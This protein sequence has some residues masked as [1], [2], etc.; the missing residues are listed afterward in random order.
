[1]LRPFGWKLAEPRVT[2]SARQHTFNGGLDESWR[3]ERERD[4]HVDGANAAA[5][6]NGNFNGVGDVASDKFVES[7]ASARDSFDQALACIAADRSKRRSACWFGRQK[8]FAFLLPW[9]FLPGDADFR[10]DRGPGAAFYRND[11]FLG[12]HVDAVDP[13][14]DQ[15][16]IVLTGSRF[17]SSSQNGSN[18]AFDFRRGDTMNGPGKFLASL[19][20][21]RGDII[22]IF[23]ACRALGRRDKC[24]G[25]VPPL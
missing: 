10:G 12:A 18:C 19:Q 2:Y 13:H 6:A 14:S 15:I 4:P 20:Q 5:F 3:K 1:M 24:C 22:T 17:D 21:A 8:D 16:V 7:S 23:T 9:R 25:R 11:Q